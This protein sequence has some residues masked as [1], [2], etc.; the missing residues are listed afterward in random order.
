MASK[1][2]LLLK[3]KP[4]WFILLEETPLFMDVPR[5]LVLDLKSIPKY[6][7]CTEFDHSTHAK[8]HS[9]LKNATGI[10][11]C[12]LRKAQCR[13]ST[14]FLVSSCLSPNFQWGWLRYNRRSSDLPKVTQWVTVSP[15]IRIQEPPGST[16][17][18]LITTPC[19]LRNPFAP[20]FSN[21]RLHAAT[22][23]K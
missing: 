11:I 23:L 3:C 19:I 17:L 16:F 21:S 14:C 4:W 9:T 15:G 2:Q 22:L 1:G 7:S 5:S 13:L 8:W 20:S 6:C 10:V 18:G 12:F